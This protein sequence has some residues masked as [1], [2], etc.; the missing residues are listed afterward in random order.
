MMLNSFEIDYRYAQPRSPIRVAGE[1]YPLPSNLV[2]G[3][4]FLRPFLK[5]KGQRIE[6]EVHSY[7]NRLDVLTN[8]VAIEYNLEPCD[9]PAMNFA[10]E[11]IRLLNAFATPPDFLEVETEA[12]MVFR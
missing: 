3:L 10:P 6:K 4:E 11:T 8:N 7:G 5:R 12:K 9:L 2:E 1:R